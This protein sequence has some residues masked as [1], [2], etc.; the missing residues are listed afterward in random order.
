M[1]YRNIKKEPNRKINPQSGFSKKLAD[2]KIFYLL[3]F[4]AL[5]FFLIILKLIQVN[6]IRGE[7]L[8]RQALNQLTKSEVL[9]AGRGKIYDRNKKE[10]AINISR[11]TCYYN[12]NFGKEKYKNAAELN[13]FK[14]EVVKKDSQKIAKVLDLDPIELQAK[15]KG[16]KMVKLSTGLSREKTLQLRDLN[17]P[18]LSVEDINSRLY[19]YND[20]AANLIGF[21]DEE[22]QGQYGIESRY[23]EEITGIAGKNVSIKNN[24]MTKIPLTD[25]QNFAPKEGLCPVL[26]LDVSIQQFAEEA[27]RKAK[28]EHSAEEVSII[29]QDTKTSEILAMADSDSFDLNN[30]KDAINEEQEESWEDL[31]KEEQIDEW[32]KNWNNFCVSSQYEPGS[33]FKLITAAAALEEATTSPNKHYTCPGSIDIGI[34]ITCT[35]KSPGDKTMTEAMAQSCNISLVKIGRELGPEKFYK[36]LK[37]FGFGSKTGIDLPAEASGSIPGSDEDISLVKLATMSYGHGVAVTPIQLINAVSAIANGG[38]LNVPRVVER[39]EDE[40]GNII[41]KY[42]TVSERQVISEET[43]D[44]MKKIMREVVENGTAKLAKIDG[45]KV[46]G[47]TGTANV[48]AKDGKGYEQ[49]AYISS[50]VGVAPLDDPQITVLVIVQKPKGDFFASTVA[51]PA[52]REVMEKSLEYLKIPKTESV[53]EKNENKISVPNVRN[54][55]LSDAGKAIIDLGLKFNTNSDDITDISTVIRQNPS[56]GMTVAEGSII[57]LFVDNNNSKAKTM[58]SLIGKKDDEL[59]KILK[60]LKIDYNIN[61]RGEVVSQS[62]SPG[63]KLKEESFLELTMSIKDRENLEEENS[64]ENINNSNN[65]DNNQ[66]NDKKDKVKK[67]EKKDSSKKKKN[68]GK[69]NK[70]TEIKNNKENN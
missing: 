55:L 64:Q 19:P 47:K 4:M 26:S 38:K 59:E 32:F 60:L 68:K 14:K 16:D 18:N 57:D 8:T 63:S 31:T 39:L 69:S 56:P 12:M 36:Y 46:G 10:L 42:K 6:V 20:M 70:N 67:S 53:D 24:F 3:I 21:T 45:Y 29:V 13:K 49:N 5:L 34:K 7:E 54:L 37:A 50:F 51:V 41:E 17:I 25:E 23:D 15:L 40:N 11:G 9:Q 44:T 35:D 48:V 28:E 2:Q 58:P 43:S 62:I 1:N 22:G 30:P 61:G 27:A 66:K 65:I 33:T 52:A